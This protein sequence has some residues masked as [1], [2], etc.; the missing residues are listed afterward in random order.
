MYQL[1]HAQSMI[2]EALIVII[3]IVVCAIIFAKPELIADYLKA[4]LDGARFN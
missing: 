4:R 2:I 3:Q 1:T